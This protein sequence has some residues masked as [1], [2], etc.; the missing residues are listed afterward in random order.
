[1]TIRVSPTEPPA[2]KALGRPTMLPENFGADVLFP[3]RLGLVGIQRKEFPGDFLGS[4][5]DG[6]LTEQRAKLQR[7]SVR[8][9]V[10]EGKGKW[11]TDGELIVPFGPEWS[12][13]QHRRYLWS[14]QLDGIWV[15][16]TANLAETCEL[17]EDM[18]AWA[19]KSSHGAGGRPKPKGQWG[20][21]SDKDWGRHLL[22]SFDGVGPE[23]ADR[24]FDHFGEVPMA[25]TCTPDELAEVHGV[26]PK[27]VAKMMRG[28]GA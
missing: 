15:S 2:L 27:R 28:L 26:G 22:T 23:M 12:A 24:I 21:P 9:L 6:R 3:S 19:D 1:M 4:V 11:T 16:H 10:L 20:S 7:C 5:H 17:V 8:L 25:W 13:S 18:V 14:V